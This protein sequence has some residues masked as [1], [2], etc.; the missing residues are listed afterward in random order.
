MKRRKQI[1]KRIPEEAV[2]D[3]RVLSLKIHG[4]ATIANVYRLTHHPEVQRIYSV[5]G[6]VLSDLAFDVDS[7]SFQLEGKGRP[8]DLSTLLPPS[9]SKAK[10]DRFK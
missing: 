1:R 10:K 8:V 3:L 5:V 6:S 4:I 2:Q 7:I 9:P